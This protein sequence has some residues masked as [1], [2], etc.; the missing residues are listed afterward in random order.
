MCWGGCFDSVECALH[1]LL[2][3]KAQ[4]SMQ[5]QPAAVAV[6]QEPLPYEVMIFKWCHV[7]IHSG[8]TWVSSFMTNE[9]YSL[10]N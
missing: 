7:W 5:L 8:T 1:A 2:E 9:E 4:I 10:H 6:L 3:L